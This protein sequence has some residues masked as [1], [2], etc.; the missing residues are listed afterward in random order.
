M[1][2]VL[3]GLL[4]MLMIM[5]SGC[6]VRA[7]YHSAPP[8]PPPGHHG[9]YRQNCYNTCAHWGWRSPCYGCRAQR[10]CLRNET[11]CR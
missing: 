8:P 6:F 5:V 11:R 3:L 1:R 9:H 4:A 2:P 7:P 10:V